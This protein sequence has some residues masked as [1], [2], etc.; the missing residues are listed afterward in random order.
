MRTWRSSARLA[1]YIPLVALQTLDLSECK[2]IT[3]AG[4]QELAPNVSVIDQD[5]DPPLI[6]VGL[7]LYKATLPN[8][9]N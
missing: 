1:L 9:F 8:N 5:R 7:K 3:D 4:V 2:K 6:K